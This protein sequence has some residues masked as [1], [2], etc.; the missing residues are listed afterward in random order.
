MTSNRCFR[1]S[2]VA[3]R[4]QRGYS[5]IELGIALGILSVII[6]GSLVGVQSILRSNRSIDMLKAVPSYMATAVKVTANQNLV[7]SVTTQNLI[8]LGVFPAAKVA[9]SG[10]NRYVANE[11]GGQI[12]LTGNASAIGSYAAG[13]TFVLSLTNIPQQACADVAS[14]LDSIAYAMNIETSNANTIGTVDASSA[15]KP[16]NSSALAIG[17]LATAC[18]ASGAKR[19]TVAVARS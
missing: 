1:G 8:D 15:V 4:N 7:S 16:A 9:D 3:W 18:G 17:A 11:H 10:S 2:S 12:H 5:L 6:V 14:G 19:I 13:Q